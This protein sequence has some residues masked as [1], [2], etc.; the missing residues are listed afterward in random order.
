MF[1]LGSLY[2]YEHTSKAS[3]PV[4]TRRAKGGLHA[5]RCHQATL[6]R[7]KIKVS[8]NRLP[9]TQGLCYSPSKFSVNLNWCHLIA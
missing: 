9:H 7:S 3:H 2:H 1:R 8:E 5:C 6:F 4:M